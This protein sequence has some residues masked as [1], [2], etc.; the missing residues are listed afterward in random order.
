[1]CRP[2]LHR[3]R[4]KKSSGVLPVGHFALVEQTRVIQPLG[5][6]HFRDLLR[7]SPAR[8]IRRFAPGRSIG[9]AA[10]RC[11]LRNEPFETLDIARGTDTRGD[12]C[13]GGLAEFGLEKGF[14]GAETA[15]A[16]QRLTS[17]SRHAGVG[18]RLEIGNLRAGEQRE[19]PR[20]IAPAKDLTDAPRHALARRAGRSDRTRSS[21]PPGA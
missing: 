3:G 19:S 17:R 16:R 5:R 11:D 2:R 8:W 15:S 9:R 4:S 10:L 21:T 6:A 7:A 20:R 18:D 13:S 14:D 12:L 1:M